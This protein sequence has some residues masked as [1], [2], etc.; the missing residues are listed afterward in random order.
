MISTVEPF[1][2]EDIKID[3][4]TLKKEFFESVNC[5]LLLT[6]GINV[7]S[8]LPEDIEKAHI[9][10]MIALQQALPPDNMPH[11][12]EEDDSDTEMYVKKCAD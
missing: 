1:T 6:D 12:F 5:Q 4:E 9:Q 8:F 2:S 10:A 11:L 7:Q 3:G